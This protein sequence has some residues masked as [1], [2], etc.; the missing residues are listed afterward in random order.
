MKQSDSNGH[1]EPTL[2]SLNK[3]HFP[4][5]LTFSMTFN[6]SQGQLSCSLMLEWKMPCPGFC[7]MES[8][9]K[10]RNNCL[11][12]VKFLP[13]LYRGLNITL[14]LVQLP[15]CILLK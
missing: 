13:V 3:G 12:Q 5:I 10:I 14:P 9:V 2:L 4:I 6:K 7:H 8:T 11:K 15:V 1:P